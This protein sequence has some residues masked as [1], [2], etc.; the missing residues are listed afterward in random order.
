MVDAEK[1]TSHV[2]EIVA[3]SAPTDFASI[4]TLASLTS[5]GDSTVDGYLATIRAQVTTYVS[6]EIL[7]RKFAGSDFP[8][9]PNI[10]GEERG[11]P[12]ERVDIPQPYYLRAAIAIRP[13]PER[14]GNPDQQTETST[15]GVVLGRWY[16]NVA[17]GL[18]QTRF[19]ITISMHEDEPEKHERNQ[20]PVYIRATIQ[21][22][23]THGGIQNHITEPETLG[24]PSQRLNDQLYNNL[25]PVRLSTLS[26]SKQIEA[27]SADL[28]EKEKNQG[29][30]VRRT[31]RIGDLRR[32]IV[33]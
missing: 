9:D 14:G 17:S 4:P 7:G 30:V 32:A 11:T 8:N 15:E 27:L 13:H 2:D 21:S 10:V 19:T 18:I 3:P 25:V 28:H 22:Q 24:N 29:N 20:A 31:T 23:E 12:L 6:Q 1:F 5:E 33:V 16:I 26:P